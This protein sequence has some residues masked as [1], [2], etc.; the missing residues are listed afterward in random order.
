MATKTMY[1]LEGMERLMF[2]NRE[3]A[4]RQQE[5]TAK[6]EGAAAR[7]I[8]VLEVEDTG[9]RPSFCD[10]WYE[11]GTHEGWYGYAD[12]RRVEDESTP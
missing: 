1:A 10:I 9:D 2:S 3:M 11:D 6:R 5:R 8:V 12:G 4:E 7:K